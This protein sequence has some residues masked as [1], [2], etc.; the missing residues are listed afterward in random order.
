MV[1]ALD[2]F[3]SDDSEVD[4]R[5]EMDN[6]LFGAFPEIA[7]SQYGIIRR[8]KT[9][10]QGNLLKCPCTDQI[11]NEADK[12]YFCPVCF[13][14]KF[15]WTESLAQFYRVSLSGDGH[16]N[17]TIFDKTQGFGLTN[18]AVH[19]FYFRFDTVINK[20][21]K[22]VDISLDNEGGIIYPIK[23]QVIWRINDIIRFRGSRGRIEYIKI[24][25][26]NEDPKY[27]GPPQG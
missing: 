4:I 20:Q 3:Y 11:T 2:N 14:E 21:D 27:L 6:F 22:I 7:K 18:I 23:R 8:M 13:G 12:D 1:V 17:G 15:F 19:I 16:G 9:D 24:F 26:N 25:C 10:D 5:V